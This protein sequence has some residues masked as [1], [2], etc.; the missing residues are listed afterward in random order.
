V[1]GSIFICINGG[2]FWNPHVD[3]VELRGKDL[4]SGK[5]EVERLTDVKKDPDEGHDK[6][7]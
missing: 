2:S 5:E 3:Y 7:G 4:S 1:L 6:E